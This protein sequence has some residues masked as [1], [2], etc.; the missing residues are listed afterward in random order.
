MWHSLELQKRRGLYVAVLFTLPLFI[1]VRSS[2]GD[3][4]ES[5]VDSNILLY[6]SLDGESAEGSG[7]S[8]NW[9]AT[10]IDFPPS[11]FVPGLI[12][13]ALRF[14]GSSYLSITNG[15]SVS[16][17]KGFTL[18]LLFSGTNHTEKT[19][20]ARSEDVEGNQWSLSINP[21]G[22]AQWELRDLNSNVQT[23]YGV[24]SVRDAQ[25][26][27]W[28][29]L[30][31]TYDPANF[32]A[33]IYV[34]GVE[35]AAQD[36]AHWD[37][38]T[39]V[40]WV[41]GDSSGAGDHPA[42]SLDEVYFFGAALA[43][44]PVNQ[45]AKSYGAGATDWTS[46][47]FI[48]NLIAGVG[49][50]PDPN[51]L[52]TSTNW[53]KV[54]GYTLAVPSTTT[55]PDI[56]PLAAPSASSDRGVMTFRAF[57]DGSDFVNIQSNTVWY[58][59]RNFELPGKWGGNDFDTFINGMAWHPEWVGGVSKPFTNLS[60]P[61][62]TCGDV[63]ITLDSWNNDDP[64]RGVGDVSI[65]QQPA[66]ENGYTAIVL[67]D[68]DPPGGPDWYNF[69]ISWNIVPGVEIVAP[70]ENDV[71]LKGEEIKWVAK[72][73]SPAVDPSSVSWEFS[74]S[75][76]S[77]APASGVGIQ[78]GEFREFQS[79]VTSEGMVKLKVK[80]TVE[81]VTCETTRSIETVAPEIVEVDFEDDIPLREWK[82][83]NAGSDFTGPQWVKPFG[84]TT[85][86][87]DVPAA[88]VRTQ[89]G[90]KSKAK[91]ILKLQAAK[92]LT[93]P[94]EIDLFGK[95]REN[96][97]DLQSGAKT[98]KMESSPLY[99]SNN[100]YDKLKIQWKYIVKKLDGS[101][102][103]RSKAILVNTSEHERIYTVFAQPTTLPVYDLALEKVCKE[104][105]ANGHNINLIASRSNSGIDNDIC[106]DPGH[107][108]PPRSVPLE[109]Y[110]AGRCLC[111]DLA[112][113]LKLLSESTGIA[114]DVRFFWGGN[115][116]S[117]QRFL[118][119]FNPVTREG[120][121][122]SFQAD[123]NGHDRASLHQHFTF[124]AQTRIS[125]IYYDPSFGTVGRASSLHQCQPPWALPSSFQEGAVLPTLEPTPCGIDP[126]GPDPAPPGC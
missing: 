32:K 98:E 3:P 118:F 1:Q 63:Q 74:Y 124:H 5:G 99:G 35:D 123:V 97:Q 102:P 79:T 126:H 88:Y 40:A 29:H 58:V 108:L 75:E 38:S 57:I 71:H 68:D 49:R 115:S 47:Q 122:A 65:T 30:A 13:N 113:L 109:A 50:P 9:V 2:D 12:S 85:P 37:F 100:F 90:N 39:P 27:R 94:V 55:V 91:L 125:G 36:V 116:T 95:G 48:K 14:A 44:D 59:H 34:D 23:I 64:G 76:G 89:P 70:N 119:E 82:P 61:L 120:R 72:L 53:L 103:P 28:S 121:A 54:Y 105:A 73:T 25:E 78:N 111:S 62:S 42:F 86:T 41:F 10:M 56:Q 101:F 7:N 93:N 31:T 69:Q 66:P 20:L 24:T 92:S 60:P 51:L 106:Y 114:G 77:G 26:G 107:R 33:R 83:G 45:L 46:G 43:A 16:V 112:E 80:V 4:W 96:V 117:Q 110:T 11:P 81:G 6:H 19:T 22:T 87:R 15:N 104:Y 84:A 67:V 21:Q 52:A 8:G 17:G 18:S